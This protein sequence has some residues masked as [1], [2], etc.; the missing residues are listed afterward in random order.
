MKNIKTRIHFLTVIVVLLFTVSCD[1]FI[2]EQPI[3]EIAPDNFW[4][5]NAD[6]NSGVIAIYDG[7]Q[8][9]FRLK[10]YF[11]GELRATDSYTQGSESANA[12]NLEVVF[13][14]VTSGNGNVLRWNDF[15]SMINRANLAIKFIPQIEGFDTSLLAEAYAIRAYAYF[16]AIRTWGDVPLFLEPIEN[17]NQETQKPRTAAN[18]ILNEVIIP[19]MLAAEDNMENFADPYRFTLTSIW[20][21]QAEVYAWIGEDANAKIALEKLID[22][23]EF[24]LVTTPFAWQDLF[25][26]DTG[27]GGGPNKVQSGPE[28]ILSIRFDIN[29]PRDNPGQTRANR[30]G[31][32]A[33]YFAGLP[34][35]YLSPVLENKW[36]EKFPID[37]LGWVTKYPDTDPALNVSIDGGDLEPLYGDWRYFFSREGGAGGIGSIEIGEAR[38]A[39]YNKANYSQDL[40]DSDIVLFRYSGMILLL[41][42]VENRLGN[43]ARALEL[44]NEIRTARQ[45]PPVTA[46]EFGANEDERENFILDERQLELLGEGKRWWDLRRTNKAIQ[47]LNPILDTIP[48]GTPLTEQRLLLPIFDQHLSENPL[49]DQTPGY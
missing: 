1:D 6:A 3:S 28:L 41:A 38:L 10:H 37:S 29:E 16:Q 9:T 17:V 5:N 44:V 47:V 23:N 22:S 43:D 8:P 30:S 42:E 46:V 24:S 32:F 20:A 19:D 45:L 31:I 11:W 25:L 39:K 40:D 7:M 34:S 4:Q 14:S 33:L 13:N 36:I 2:D 26:N 35:Y 48:G 15:Y 18:T 27:D 49:L 12:D 21:F